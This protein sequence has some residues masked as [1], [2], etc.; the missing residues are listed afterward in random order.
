MP[1][2]SGTT[3]VRR[4]NVTL[5]PDIVGLLDRVAAKGVRSRVIAEAVRSYDA[6]QSSRRIRELMKEP[7]IRYAR[8]D[9]EIAAE[10][11][12]LKEEAWRLRKM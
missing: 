9:L 6:D 11:F 1:R 4:L 7:A 12:P 5:P 8:R 2:K 3:G 10:W